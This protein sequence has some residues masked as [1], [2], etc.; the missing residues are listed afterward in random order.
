MT[1]CEVFMSKKWAAADFIIWVT[2]HSSE[3][4]SMF[5]NNMEM[6]LNHPFFGRRDM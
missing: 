2:P 5:C 1:F 4:I 3:V 6:F